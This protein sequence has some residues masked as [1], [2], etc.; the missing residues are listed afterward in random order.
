M[1]SPLLILL[2]KFMSEEKKE[3]ESKSPADEIEDPVKAGKKAIDAHNAVNK[4][5]MPAKQKDKEE[6]ED[7]ENW[8]N[9]G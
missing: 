6:K 9:E 8:R 1:N 3:P 7:A 2:K 5:D 4:Q